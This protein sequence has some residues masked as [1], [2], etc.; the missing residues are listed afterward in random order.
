MF[1][2]I[3]GDDDDDDEKNHKQ[4]SIVGSVLSTK[5]IVSSSFDNDV[6][7]KNKNS[8]LTSSSCAEKPTSQ[9]TT[10]VH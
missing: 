4:N 10:Q 5:S 6:G 9:F 1:S 2:K 8:N 3:G 7:D